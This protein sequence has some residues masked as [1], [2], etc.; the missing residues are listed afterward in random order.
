MNNQ[1]HN[2]CQQQR[3][4]CRPSTL[5]LGY[6]HPNWVN[7]VE[8]TTHFIGARAD[9]RSRVNFKF[10]FVICTCQLSI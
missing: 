3:V 9:G 7:D 2:A 1:I 8:I 6:L 4:Q 10:A 5:F